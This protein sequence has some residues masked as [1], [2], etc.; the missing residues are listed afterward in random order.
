MKACGSYNAFRDQL[1]CNP[2][3]SAV[4]AGIRKDQ[5]S[6][7]F[8]WNPDK[9]VDSLSGHRLL[10]PCYTGIVGSIADMQSKARESFVSDTETAE[11]MYRNEQIRIQIAGVLDGLYYVPGLGLSA[12][13]V[14]KINEGGKSITYIALPDVYRDGPFNFCAMKLGV[15][16]WHEQNVDA[17]TPMV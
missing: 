11:D 4:S 12:Q 15:T 10:V 17:Q 14:L 2:P 13:D 9:V 6:A 8:G 16:E 3:L 7:H 1:G 5:V